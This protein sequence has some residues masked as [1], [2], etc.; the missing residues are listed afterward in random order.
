M[1]DTA[2]KLAQSA[3]LTVAA[4]AVGA[5]LG[6]GLARVAFGQPAH[7]EAAPAGAIRGAGALTAGAAERVERAAASAASAAPAAAD[8]AAKRVE[9]AG[10]ALLAPRYSAYAAPPEELRDA[11]GLDSADQDVLAAWMRNQC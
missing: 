2:R 4:G 5:A 10:Q 3:A 7:A 8:D 11:G 9:R 6:V 1:T